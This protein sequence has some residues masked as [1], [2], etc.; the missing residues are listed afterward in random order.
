MAR[1]DGATGSVHYREWLVRRPRATTVLVHG[2][3]EHSGLYGRLAAGLNTRGIS[4]R[5][6]DQIGHGRTHGRRGTI[7]SIDDL[8]SDVGL[9]TDI[10]IS[11][12]SGTPV[13][14]IGHS[15]GGI[16]AAVTASRRPARYAG[17]VLSGATLSA[18]A[19][20]GG[21]DDA[22]HEDYD[23]D[24]DDAD[25]SADPAYLSWLRS[26]PLVFTS[27]A[28]I[29]D[30]LQRILPPAWEELGANLPALDI[31]ALFIHGEADPVSAVAGAREW[32]ARLA[33]GQLITFPGARHD[34]LN[35]VAHE[36]VMSAIAEFVL[37]TAPDRAAASRPDEQEV[38]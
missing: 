17:V 1:F 22:G 27:G 20:F 32:S 13:F 4:V 11:R 35:E 30:S 23:L 38:P 6:L 19:G 10:A 2:V 21:G 7:T 24:L 8:V 16:V 34:V 37:A 25:L 3:G 29:N 14:A 12:D 5:A 36:A 18:P 31:P 28:E 9:L 15:L 26:D 33:R